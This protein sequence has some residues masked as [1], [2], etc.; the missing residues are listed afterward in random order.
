MGVP[1]PNSPIIRLCNSN[2]FSPCA[3]PVPTAPRNFPVVARGI[4]S[5]SLSRCLANSSTQTAT[6]R[7]NVIGTAACPCVLPS[8]TV[9]LSRSAISHMVPI[10]FSRASRCNAILSLIWRATAESTM[11]LL[12][13]PRWMHHPASPAASAIAL[14]SAMISCFVSA[15]ISST[16]SAVTIPGSAMSAM[17]S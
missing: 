11:S 16:L 7:P 5:L 12:V 10:R 4:N 9:S 3:A 8:I 17:A 2:A 6:F 14:V 13:A 15:S 1:S